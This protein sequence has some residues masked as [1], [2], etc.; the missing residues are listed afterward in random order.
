MSEKVRPDL[1]DS[2]TKHPFNATMVRVLDP[3]P[4]PRST[5]ALTS[6]AAKVREDSVAD[7]DIRPGP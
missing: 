7:P 6:L 4:L 2:H 1:L 3:A 5:K